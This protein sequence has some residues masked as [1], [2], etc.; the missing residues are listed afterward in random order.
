[1]HQKGRNKARIIDIALQAG[2]STATVD[3]VL[4]NRPGVRQKTTDKVN[5]A[6]HSLDRAEQRPRIVLTLDTDIVIDA[7]IA[8][9]AGFPNKIL[10]AELHRVARERGTT[11]RFTYPRRLNPFALADALEQ[12]RKRTSSGIIVQ[13]LGHPLVREKVTEIAAEGIPVVAIMTS[14]PGSPTIGYVGLTIELPAA[15]PAI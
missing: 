9:G 3:R 2:V 12:S 11:L 6:I 15:R 5:A 1:M 14:L 4:N 10:A 8:G 13:A 7:V